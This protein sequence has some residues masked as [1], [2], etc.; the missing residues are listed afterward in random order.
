MLDDDL[1]APFD[2][3]V[4]IGAVAAQVKS[5]VVDVEAAIKSWSSAI[6]RIEN[7]RPTKA[8]V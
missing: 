8:P 6:Q 1:G 7:Q 5:G 3:L 4:T 2:R